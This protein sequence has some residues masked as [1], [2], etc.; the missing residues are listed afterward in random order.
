MR[1]ATLGVLGALPAARQPA[2]MARVLAQ[3]EHPEPGVR[4]A[5]V[6]ALTLT[7]TLT[8]TLP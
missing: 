5:A 7:L 6:D 8:L 1:I 3:L 4:A 2:R